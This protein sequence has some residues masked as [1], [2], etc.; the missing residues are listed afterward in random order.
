M[1]PMKVLASWLLEHTSSTHYLYSFWDLRSLFCDL[2]DS[3]YKTLLSRA[4]KAQLLTRVCRGVYLYKLL[5]L[6]LRPNRIKYRDLWDILWLHQQGVTPRF[7]LIPDKL[8]ERNLTPFVFLQH[9]QERLQM[10]T[11]KA[12]LAK[13]FFQE[14]QRFLPAQQVNQLL[15]QDN[16]WSFMQYLTAKHGTKIA[17]ICKKP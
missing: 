7:E 4:V 12:S 8:K 14:M 9:Y 15:Q 16:I 13:E 1:Q 5:A 10:L 3:A 2:S 17:E 11:E 6:A